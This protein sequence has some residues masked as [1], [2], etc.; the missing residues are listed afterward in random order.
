MN[1]F[2]IMPYFFQSLNFTLNIIY[3]RGISG[4]QV[5]VQRSHFLKVSITSTTSTGTALQPD[6]DGQGGW[7][8]GISGGVEPVEHMGTITDVHVAPVLAAS[9]GNGLWGRRGPNCE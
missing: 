5:D 6:D 1:T 8:G 9:A 2:N 4:L 3:P 7:V